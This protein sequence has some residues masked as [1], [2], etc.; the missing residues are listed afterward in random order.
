MFD[1]KSFIVAAII[2][3]AFLAGF[4][5]RSH[6]QRRYE[7]ESITLESLSA[8]LAQHFSVNKQPDD[9]GA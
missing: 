6:L 4:A 9:P 7:A 1:E 2:V 3:L 8:S 5:F